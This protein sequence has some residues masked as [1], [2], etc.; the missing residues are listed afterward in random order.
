MNCYLFINAPTQAMKNR[1]IQPFV[2]KTITI[3]SVE[4]HILEIDR[5]DLINTSIFDGYVWYSLSDARNIKDTG[6][7]P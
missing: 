1:A 2:A 3:S 5:A 4:Y 6:A 7:F